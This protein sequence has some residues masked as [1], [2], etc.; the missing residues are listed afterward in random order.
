MLSSHFYRCLPLVSLPL[1]ISAS[2]VFIR[3]SCFKT[4]LKYFTCLFLFLSSTLFSFQVFPRP[5]HLTLVSMSDDQFFLY[6]HISMASIL[7]SS[8]LTIDQV[9]TPTLKSFKKKDKAYQALLWLHA[10]SQPDSWFKPALPNENREM[11]REVIEVGG[12]TSPI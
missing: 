8:Y 11:F 9:Y 1:I 10:M 12:R 6:I 7:F 5:L 3:V 4:W 2:I